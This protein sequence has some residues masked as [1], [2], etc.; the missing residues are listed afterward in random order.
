VIAGDMLRGTSDGLEHV[1]KLRVE[2]QVFAWAFVF[3]DITHVDDEIQA[4][5][6][7]HPLDEGAEQ[8][9]GK[10]AELAKLAAMFGLSPKVDIRNE[11][12]S[13]GDSV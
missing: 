7:V 1:E 2:R 3:D 8:R 11:P 9:L 5:E 4:L 12:E 6:S 13:H 10:V